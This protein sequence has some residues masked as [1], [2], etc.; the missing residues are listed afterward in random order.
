MTPEERDRMHALCARIEVEK[1]HEE[2]TRLV[3][4]LNDLLEG[5]DR[6]LNTAFSGTA[7]SKP[8]SA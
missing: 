5:K 1:D 6:R 2:F 8:E 4:E 3:Q 7:S